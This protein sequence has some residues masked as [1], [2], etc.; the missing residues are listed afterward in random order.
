MKTKKDRYLGKGKKKE[1][2]EPASEM[3][4]TGATKDKPIFVGHEVTS[5]K[6]LGDQTKLKGTAIYKNKTDY[7]L[8]EYEQATI[9]KVKPHE[10]IIMSRS[11]LKVVEYGGSPKEE[12][13][14]HSN[15]RSKASLRPLSGHTAG[16]S[17]SKSRRPVIP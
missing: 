9:A 6:N 1:P 2:E 17:E 12:G 13:E 15:G 8:S 4:L 3:F 5:P 11:H 16:T 10:A 14:S 7:N